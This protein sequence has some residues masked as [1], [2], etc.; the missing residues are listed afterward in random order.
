ML[1]LPST[2]IAA[3]LALLL[4]AT[5]APAALAHASLLGTEP[6]DGA[7]LAA[8]PTT[9]ILRFN[10][11]VSPTIV[12]LVKPDG[13]SIELTQA[14]A[15]DATV[16]ISL[17]SPLSQGTHL[18]SWRVVSADG[19]PVGGSF[20]FSVGASS[21]R[22]DAAAPE[23]SMVAAHRLLW[24]AKLSLYL[25]LLMGVGGAFAR[26]VLTDQGGL[27][28]TAER[29]IRGVLLVGAAATVAHVCLQGLDLLDRPLAEATAPDSWA[30]GLSGGAGL[31][32]VLALLAHA[33]A[34]GSFLADGRRA[35]QF[36]TG[37]AMVALG[38][39]LASTGHAA[40][41]A[42]RAVTRPAVFF[43][44]I[45]VAFWVG[46]L[47]PLGSLFGAAH[48]DR[49]TALLR[50]SRAIPWSLALLIVTGAILACIQ[51]AT[52]RALWTTAYGAI[53]VLKLAVVAALL[54]IA[55]WN[56][57]G[58]TPPLLAGQRAADRRFRRTV[59]LELLLV[60]VILGLVAGWRFT[61]P[62]RALQAAQAA[63]LPMHVHGAGA[64]AD[65]EVRFDRGAP[66]AIT[67]RLTKDGRT[68]LHAREV[69]VLL[70][71]PESG[72][73]AV[74]RVARKG[75]NGTWSITGFSL[76]NAGRW[77]LRIDV[78]VSD[79]E[80]IRLETDTLLP[81]SGSD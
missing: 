27:P 70:D 45:S 3:L 10:E 16:R 1:R 61:P 19:H 43:H 36:L 63:T 18:V 60:A 64:M 67:I 48:A 62:P 7:V 69:V 21:S 56:R 13:T 9:V 74:K 52:I 17:P 14:A 38:L 31:L 65:L 2:P 77:R 76:P 6:P 4:A 50:F 11:P 24:L 29:A 15:S 41:A 12:R 30:A 20:L 28:R 51:V 71:S 37:A 5:W 53:L 39:A 23:A 22:P 78:L 80:K 8:A 68:P 57:Y 35:R 32:A 58:L 73:E 81:V 66:A 34:F 79:F 59:G 72:L 49:R 55:A 47:L 54:T 46:A 40:N 44:A 42:P 25:G 26:A 75:A 33:L